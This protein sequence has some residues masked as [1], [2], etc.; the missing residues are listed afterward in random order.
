MY[1]HSRWQKIP[2]TRLRLPTTMKTTVW[3]EMYDYS[4][5]QF[6][7]TSLA[8]IWWQAT[9]TRELPLSSCLLAFDSAHR[10][11]IMTASQLESWPIPPPTIPL[12]QPPLPHPEYKTTSN[13]ASQHAHAY[14]PRARAFAQPTYPPRR[15]WPRAAECSC[16]RC[17]LLRRW[18]PMVLVWLSLTELNGIWDWDVMWHTPCWLLWTPWLWRLWF[19]LSPFWECVYEGWRSEMWWEWGGWGGLLDG[20]HFSEVR[21]CCSVCVEPN[22]QMGNVGIYTLHLPDHFNSI[23]DAAWCS[24]AKPWFRDVRVYVMGELCHW[25]NGL[26]SWRRS[27]D[28]RLRCPARYLAEMA[29]V[30]GWGTVILW[31]PVRL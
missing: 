6:V 1:Q 5:I 20:I 16:A 12:R 11:S 26:K 22:S 30:C 21:V 27:A 15:S 14:Q 8:W 3:T 29:C 13:Y 7:T 24:D 17:C 25:R 28:W 10:V 19:W 23:L 2:I 4:F 9:H 18:M 31:L